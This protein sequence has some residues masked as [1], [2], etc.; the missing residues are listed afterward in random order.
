MNKYLTLAAKLLTDGKGE[1]TVFGRSMEPLFQSG[2]TLAYERR[3]TY[4]V[5]DVVYS[6]VKGRPIDAHKITKIDQA[7]RYLISNNHG[8]DNGWTRIIYGKVVRVTYK[9]VTTEL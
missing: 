9:G 2:S 3:D 4:A 6:K 1:M 8:F 5:G 7:G